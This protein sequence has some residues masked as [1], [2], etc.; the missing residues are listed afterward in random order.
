MLYSSRGAFRFRQA[1]QTEFVAPSQ[2]EVSQELFG[3]DMER[4]PQAHSQLDAP[5]A[6]KQ[7][8]IQEV[9]KMGP[10]SRDV[11]ITLLENCDGDIFRVAQRLSQNEFQK[12]SEVIQPVDAQLRPTGEPT[13]R[14]FYAQS[15]GSPWTL[16]NESWI[17]VFF[18]KNIN[19][20]IYIYTNL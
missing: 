11:A 7:I 8:A 18:K 16:E 12:V 9:M 20:Y 4:V 14:H 3:P 1:V 15:H 17:N 6:S 5:T 10:F 13:E 19:I 2:R